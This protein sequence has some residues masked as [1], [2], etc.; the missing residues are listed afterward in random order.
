M[1]ENNK[2]QNKEQVLTAR[3]QEMSKMLTEQSEQ[4]KT[5]QQQ[6]A[7]VL[8]QNKVLQ[9]EKEAIEQKKLEESSD[10]KEILQEK[11]KPANAESGSVEDL[12]NAELLTIV[13]EAVETSMAANME[14]SMQKHVKDFG[15]AMVT[16]NDKINGVQSTMLKQAAHSNVS[17]LKAKYPDLNDYTADINAQLEATPGIELE[18][19]YI[20]AKAKKN[21]GLPDKKRVESER[22]NR[23]ITHN[24][25]SANVD[26]SHRQP[27][28]K[29]GVRSVRD[30]I[31][32]GVNRVIDGRKNSIYSRER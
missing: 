9:Q 12:T 13:G 23:A 19:A 3:E 6:A 11:S 18:D 29:R 28:R 16:L 5:L 31:N 1:D 25:S 21:N 32:A 10:L 8:E 24:E 27:P 22:P 14:Q 30:I 2:E 20:L 7:Q 4:L 26:D 17:T 15:T